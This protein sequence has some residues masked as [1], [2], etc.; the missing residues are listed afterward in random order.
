MKHDYDAQ[1][2]ETYETFEELRKDPSLPKMAVVDYQFFSEE[3]DAD[4]D[5][6]ENALQAKGFET[7]RYQEDDE[8]DVMEASIGPVD[9]TP[10]TIWHYEK[11][12]TEMALTFD[13]YPDGWGLVES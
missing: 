8:D 1:R 12:T 13:F 3:T 2:D 4:W 11:L 10:E 6:F 9:V 5:G 7:R